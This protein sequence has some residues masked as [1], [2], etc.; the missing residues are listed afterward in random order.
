[1]RVNAEMGDV[2]LEQSVE[3]VLKRA[4]RSFSNQF[5]VKHLSHEH[6]SSVHHVSV[7]HIHT[8]N[9]LKNEKC[10]KIGQR[11]RMMKLFITY[12]LG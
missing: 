7:C 12:D 2:Y 11:R 10:Y 3:C 4:Q 6:V 1:M 8:N 5:R 9:V